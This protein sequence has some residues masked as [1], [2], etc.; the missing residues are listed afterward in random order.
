[1]ALKVWDNES[2]ACDYTI[3]THQPMK[4]M[5]ITGE[6]NDM[7]VASLG[8]GDLIVYGLSMKNQLDIVEQAHHSTVVQIASLSK[9]ENKY[10]ATRSLEGHVNIWSATTHP[11]RLFTIEGIE[12]QE[13]SMSLDIS[14]Q[15]S[16]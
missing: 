11:D 8:E 5:A 6:R 7:L 10:F 12:K 3:E 1:M 9:L 14:K 13:E 16:T 2:E 15:E 4:A